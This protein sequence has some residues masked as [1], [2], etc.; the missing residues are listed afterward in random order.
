MQQ[1]TKEKTELVAQL[2]VDEAENLSNNEKLKDM[3][4]AGKELEMMQEGPTRMGSKELDKHK[5]KMVKLASQ[6]SKSE[7]MIREIKMKI[8][9]IGRAMPFLTS[10]ILFLGV[11]RNDSEYF[12]YVN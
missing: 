6:K 5:K 2:K 4:N 8:A 7:E 3:V 12:F 11:D 9:E 10:E 1:L